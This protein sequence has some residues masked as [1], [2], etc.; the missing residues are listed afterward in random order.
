MRLGY[1]IKELDVK[2][3]GKNLTLRQAQSGSTSGERP[4]SAWD[5]FIYNFLAMSI[6]FPWIYLQGPGMFPRANLELAILIATVAQ[7]PVS[8]A[9]SWLATILPISGGDY[10]YQTRAFGRLGFISVF[11]G[12]VVWILQWVAIS[13]Y[14][15]AKLGLAPL[16]ISLGVFLHRPG[17]S[18]LGI[19]LASPIGVFC[20]SIALAL[21][22]TLIL[23]RGLH[24]FVRVQRYLFFLTITAVVAVIWVFYFRQSLFEEHL[25]MFVKTLGSLHPGQ[26]PTIVQVGTSFA[27]FL[28]SD[29]AAS[30]HLTSKISPILQTLAVVPI[31]WTTLQWATYSVEQNTEIR[32]ADRF[33]NQVLMMVLPVLVVPLFLVLIAH[34]ELTAIPPDLLTAL[35]A[36]YGDEGAVRTHDLVKQILPPF[37]SVLAM[38]V[39]QNVV[40]VVII[41]LG[42]LANAF[43][44]ACNSF[45]GTTR[46]IVAMSTDGVLPGYMKLSSVERANRS[47]NN[48]LWIYLLASIPVIAANSLVESWRDTYGV[49]VTIGCGYVFV[50]TCLAASRIPTQ[51]RSF[52]MCSEIYSIPPLVIKTVSYLAAGLA[53]SMVFPYL[54]VPQLGLDNMASYLEIVGAVTLA[55]GLSYGIYTHAQRKRPFVDRKIRQVPKEVKASYD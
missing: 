24:L 6:I 49:G 22:A 9:Y 21:L 11:S 35:S 45:I 33:R 47:P 12:F 16:F 40:V 34:S 7:M 19:D 23:R 38:A 37:P 28:K 43:Q 55:L 39:S 44:I 42:F 20:V 14:L 25:T 10:I 27:A 1:T 29:V 36:S 2:S 26:F 41:A 13:G 30:G 8:C 53:A 31:A 18:R 4:M 50:L 5:G 51:M 32:D 15:C 52:W 46:I 17:L 54:V 48:A 3:V